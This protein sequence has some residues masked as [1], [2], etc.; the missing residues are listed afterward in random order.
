VLGVA[1]WFPGAGHEVLLGPAE[2]I[3]LSAYVS[4]SGMQPDYPAVQAVAGA[5]LAVDCAHMGGGAGRESLWDAARNLDTSTLF[6]GFRIDPEGAQ[7]KHQTVLVRWA[8]GELGV[9]TA[10]AAAGLP[11]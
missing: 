8:R 7:I 6:G 2:D 10:A 1:Q 4:Q 9:V 11:E 3:F 5:V